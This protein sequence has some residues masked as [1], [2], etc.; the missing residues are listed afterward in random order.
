M[1]ALLALWD[2]PVSSWGVVEILKLVII[3]AACIAIVVVALSVFKI[4][5]PEWAKQIFWIVV[6]AVVALIA[7]NIVASL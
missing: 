5:I 7:I 6:V 1:Y 4:T 2:R 3:V